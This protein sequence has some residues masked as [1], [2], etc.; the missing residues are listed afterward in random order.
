[1]A[2]VRA[3]DEQGDERE[4]EHRDEV[5]EV[6]VGSVEP[7]A[8]EAALL[9]ALC[10]LGERAL[11]LVVPEVAVAA[12]AA[13]LPWL[14]VE[15]RLFT[16]GP[17]G[18]EAR[19]VPV[20]TRSTV[21][22]GYDDVLV[23]AALDVTDL[24]VDDLETDGAAERSQLEARLAA[25]ELLTPM[26]IGHSRRAVSCTRPALGGP[27]LGGP[28]HGGRAPGVIDLV[29]RGDDGRVHVVRAGIGPDAALPLHGLDDL[30]WV[31]AHLAAVAELVEGDT[32]LA[33]RLD[34]V[35]MRRP[36][37]P[38][39]DP[40][41]RATLERLSREADWRLWEVEGELAGELVLSPV[42][43]SRVTTGRRWSDRMSSRVAV[44]TRFA[45]AEL[46]NGRHEPATD[47]VAPGCAAAAD[48]L[49]ARGVLHPGFGLPRS[50]QRFAVNLFGALGRGGAA[51]LLG[52]WFG[53]VVAA[54]EPVLEWVDDA[55]RLR[56]LTEARP[57]QTQ[58]DAVLRGRT[59]DDRRV[60][61]LVEVKLTESAFGDC[62]HAEDA[63]PER[64]VACT[65]P[66]P[67][68]GAPE[69]CWQLA[70]RELGAR[71]RYDLA[72]RV[73][74]P[75]P[76]DAPCDCW[77]RALNQPMRSAALASALVADGDAD[78][79]V[80]ALCAPR[81]HQAMWRQWRRATS[82][83]AERLVD[84]DPADV[85]AALQPAA[86]AFLCDRYG[87]VPSP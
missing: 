17:D 22:E 8:A 25:R 84:L 43:W 52:R 61:A 79:V 2:D 21:L 10:V 20:P 69:V 51:E 59:A 78:E 31:R 67:F 38:L 71:R 15:A 35:V 44:A 81:G 16:P 14:D 75:A 56:E 45:G 30:T 1:M 80:V 86:Q 27:A 42:W 24:G 4:D 66:G 26:G 41:A 76:P 34:L 23:A 19:E 58:V 28:A 18:G 63:P 6:V 77:F 49:A 37:G 46:V 87:I 11:H 48:D 55:D 54:D 39:L 53:D 29:G 7:G 9:D 47:G 33:P 85:A 13:R 73:V 70:N 72:L 32:D 3:G 12:I 74:D 57:H 68:G 83:L 82:V 64:R 5:L 60:V 36:G 50:S 40:A 65:S 62:S